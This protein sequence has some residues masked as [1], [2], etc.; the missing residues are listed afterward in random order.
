M[1]NKIEVIKEY[2]PKHYSAI[3][4]EGRLHQV[5]FNIIANS[6]QG[7]EE[8]GTITIFTKIEK[9]R[10]KI[11]IS[12]TGCGIEAEIKEGAKAIITIPINRV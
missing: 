2:T 6:V 3:C 7:I 5:F 9:V 1:R 10:I 12:D 11:T 8:Y 4:N